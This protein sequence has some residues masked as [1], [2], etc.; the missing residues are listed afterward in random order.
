MKSNFRSWEDSNE[1]DDEV[2]YSNFEQLVSIMQQRHPKVKLK[3]IKQA[4]A[5]WIGLE[6]YGT[7][8]KLINVNK[9]TGIFNN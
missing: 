9:K 7:S 2:K 8:Q 6:D 1:E 4:C 3:E 5:D